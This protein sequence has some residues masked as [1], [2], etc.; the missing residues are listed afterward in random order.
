MQFTMNTQFRTMTRIALFGLLTASCVAHAAAPPYTPNWESLDQ[1]ETSEWY[2]DAK[3]GI[4][5]H[6]GLYSVPAFSIRGTYAEWYWHALDSPNQNSE[7]RQKRHI[8]TNEFHKRVYGEDFE[9]KDFR[10]LFTCEMFEP[11]DY[12]L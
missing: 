8:A 3:F 10:P 12:R 9:Y 4:F 2:P 11:Q 7:K 1:R 6:W 5:I